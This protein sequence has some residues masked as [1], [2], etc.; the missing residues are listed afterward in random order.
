MKPPINVEVPM[1]IPVIEPEHVLRVPEITRMTG[2]TER[3]IRQMIADGRLPAIR[4][5]GVRIV[6]VPASAVRELMHAK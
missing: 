5:A 6:V 2:I 1:Q 4:P 3:T